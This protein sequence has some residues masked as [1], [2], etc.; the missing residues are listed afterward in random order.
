MAGI[1]E[2]EIDVNFSGEFR[3]IVEF[4]RTALAEYITRFIKKYGEEKEIYDISVYIKKFEADYFGKPLIFCSLAANTE[5]GL[6]SA[7]STGWGLKQSIRQGMKN[8]L[9]EINKLHQ[10]EL[11]GNYASV[12]A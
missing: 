5:F 12:S 4:N 3:D 1:Q 2:G 8:L 10:K 9:F 6:I 7:S 11:F